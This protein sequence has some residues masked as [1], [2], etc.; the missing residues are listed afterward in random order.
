MGLDDED[1]GQAVIIHVHSCYVTLPD[2]DGPSMS[3]YIPSGLR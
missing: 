1:D 2:M 3:K